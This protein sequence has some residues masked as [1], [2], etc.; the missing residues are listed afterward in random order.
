MREVMRRVVFCP[1]LECLTSDVNG[2]FHPKPFN[3]IIHTLDKLTDKAKLSNEDIKKIDMLE[4]DGVE[5]A[6]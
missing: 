6:P 5:L 2:S 1:V 4:S 3:Y